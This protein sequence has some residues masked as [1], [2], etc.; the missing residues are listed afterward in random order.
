VKVVCSYCKKFLRDKAPL[1]DDR[2][3]HG[4]CDPCFEHFLLQID[5]LPLTGYVEGFSSP[6]LL[7]REDWR[8][9]AMNRAMEAFLGKSEHAV[10]GLRGGEAM[11]CTY[12]ALPGGCGQTAHCEP[13]TVRRAVVLTMETGEPL[14]E[15]PAH[16]RTERGRI[17]LRISTARVD[18]V[19]RVTINEAEPPASSDSLMAGWR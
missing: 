8:V 17:E 9:V 10:Q 7:V 18:G 6:V 12:A 19:V 4:V 3:S 13:C 16:L 5:D 2:V 15:Q 1:D 11:G 14:V